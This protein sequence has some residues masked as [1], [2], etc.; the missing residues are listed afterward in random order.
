MKNIRSVYRLYFVVGIQETAERNEV[1]YAVN[2]GKQYACK[3]HSEI[4]LAVFRAL[5]LSCGNYYSEY[6]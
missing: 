1:H 2:Y 5:F 3:T 4:N 6:Q